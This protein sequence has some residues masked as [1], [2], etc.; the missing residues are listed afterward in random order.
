MYMYFD[1]IY[2]KY[3]YNFGCTKIRR[4]ETTLLLYYEFDVTR[5]PC[6]GVEKIKMK[7]TK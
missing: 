5:F 3:T 2:K 4:I 6:E 7:Q 1:F